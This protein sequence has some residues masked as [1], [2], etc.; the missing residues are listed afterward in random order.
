MLP[1]AAASMGGQGNSLAAGDT[2]SSG[3]A[4]SGPISTTFAAVNFNSPASGFLGAD[5]GWQSAALAVL[6]VVFVTAGVVALKK[7]KG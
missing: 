2:V 1:A 4:T 7:K 5:K 3:P 6:V